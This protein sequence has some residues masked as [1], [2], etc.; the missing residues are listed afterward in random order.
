VVPE[1]RRDGEGGIDCRHCAGTEEPIVFSDENWIAVLRSFSPLLGVMLLTRQHYDSF[2][3]LPANL[4]AEFGVLAARIDQ[5]LLDL[6]DVARVHL[7]RW[8]DGSAHFHVHFVPRPLG[9]L[10]LRYY[11][12]PLWERHLPPRPAEHIERVRLSLAEALAT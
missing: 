10:D 3:N 8:G 12:L 7:Y 1:P 4:Q 2:T 9:R 11:Y 5:A 6:G